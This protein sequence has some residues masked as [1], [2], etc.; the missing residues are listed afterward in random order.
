[1]SKAAKFQMVDPMAGDVMQQVARDVEERMTKA[2]DDLR[3]KHR[4][5]PEGAAQET[6]VDAPTGEAYK[7]AQ[8]EQQRA[9]RERRR[10]Q[11]EEEQAL[12]QKYSVQPQETEEDLLE[13]GTGDEDAELRSLREQRL[14]QLRGNQREKMEN[15]AK[16][17]GEYREVTQDEFLPAVT[18]SKRVV[19]H[20]YHNDYPRCAIMHHHLR[21]V[22]RQHVE[23]RFVYIDANKAPFFVPKL[24]VSC[25]DGCLARLTQSHCF[26]LLTNFPCAHRSAR[27][28]P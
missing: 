9:E 22:A 20:F 5:D 3:I 16:G 6:S 11:R 13:G 21:I 15:M 18:G 27:C 4:K 7:Q 24:G 19:C 12:K 10:K 8:L 17:H 26:I 23:T 25:P 1:M 2:M 28:Q 14:Q